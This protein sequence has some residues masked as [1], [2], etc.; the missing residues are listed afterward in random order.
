MG[1]VIELRADGDHEVGRGLPPPLWTTTINHVLIARNYSG[2][3]GGD[4]N[5]SRVLT[6]FGCGKLHISQRTRIKFASAWESKA[7]ISSERLYP[8]CFLYRSV[9]WMN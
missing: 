3:P 6:L 1:D 5:I 7:P 4:L 2:G 8:Y 9:S